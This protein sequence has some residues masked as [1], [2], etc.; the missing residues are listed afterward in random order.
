MGRISVHR[1]PHRCRCQRL[2][3]ITTTTKVPIAP[4]PGCCARQ[5]SCWSARIRRR[6]RRSGTRCSGRTPTS[7]RA[8]PRRCSERRRHRLWDIRGQ[9][10]GVADLR[11]ARR[12]GPRERPPL[13]PLPVTHSRPSR[14]WSRAR[15]ARSSG[16]VPAIKTDPFLARAPVGHRHG[17]I[18][19]QIEREREHRGVEMI[20]GI[21]KAVGPDIEV[22]IDAHGPVQRADRGP[23]GDAPGAVRHQLVRGARARPRATTRSRPVRDQVPV[24]HLR[25]RAAVH[26]LRVPAGP[27]AGTW[28]TTSCRT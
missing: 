4:S 10:L 12:R 26:A 24:P 16:V 21:R 19:G 14:R 17:Y 2:G 18:D 20:E 11:V 7:G 1:D 23:A 22:L 6:S 5:T 27:R 9:A 15:S 25:R 3:E 28:P 8:A 13:H